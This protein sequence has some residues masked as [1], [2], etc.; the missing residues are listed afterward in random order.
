MIGNPGTTVGDYIEQHREHLVERF[1]EDAG[2]LESARG[3]PQGELI[4]TLPEYLSTL[5]AISQEGRR[6]DPEKTKSRL[7]QTH[8]SLRLRQGYTQEEV[9]TEYVII[10]R[11]ITELWDDAPPEEQPSRPDTQLL[12]DEL[13]EAMDHAVSVFTGYT[14]EDRQ[15]EKRLLRR[16]DALAPD[17]LRRTD[18]VGGRLQP[19]L[20]VIQEAAVA[21]GAELYLIDEERR[22]LRFA[23][24]TGLCNDRQGDAAIPVEGDRFMAEVARSEVPLVSVHGPRSDRRFRTRMG[25]RLWP[26]GDLLGVLYVAFRQA[27]PIEP[28]VQRLFETMVEYLS[29]ILERALLF[30]RIQETEERA[31]G[32]ER[33]FRTLAEVMPQIVF[34][35]RPDGE[36][37]YMNQ[38]M[39]EFA[40]SPVEALLGSNWYELVDPELR[41][42]VESAWT[43]AL[44]TGGPY[45]VEQRLRRRDGAYRW[46]LTRAVPIRDHEGRIEKWLGTS[47]DID[48]LKR[49]EAELRQRTE[50][51]QQ[52]I[53]IVSH[54]LRNPLN[55][56]R[57][58]V[59]TL[60]RS[61]ELTDRQARAGARILN[62]AE[63]ATRLTRDLLDFT[64]AR[65]GGGIPI[66]PSPLDLHSTVRQVLDEVQLAH[67]ERTIQFRSE[68]DG[69][70]AWDGDRLAQVVTNL[71]NNALAYSR[72]NSPIRVETRADGDHVVLSVHNEG[73]PIPPELMPRLFQP[74]QRGK[75]FDSAGRSIGLGLFIVRS[76]VD[77][78]GGTIEVNSK[79]DYGT[80]FTVRLPRQ[81]R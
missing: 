33:E 79:K 3:L 1:V 21:D 63:R 69:S 59:Q 50:F 52:L 72:E 30:A 57:L 13:G 51:E 75:E 54:D 37:D 34:T 6:E 78:H 26:H 4:D 18:S 81:P 55:A 67:P 22:H 35:S 49:A 14:Q 7:E 5:V 32:R 64:Q 71:T 48:D 74:L 24:A 29:G 77:A 56:I 16:L 42:M 47:T 20:E 73:E 23:A 25:L 58:S 17:T 62:S 44:T 80:T 68:G 65:L 53:G 36:L 76:I 41:P 11:L 28:Q 2:R 8:L 39:A 15:R 61:E 31:R 60:L 9:T 10:G 19:L 43:K 70:G 12:F 27:K 45:E 46:H 40:G 66:V 38:R